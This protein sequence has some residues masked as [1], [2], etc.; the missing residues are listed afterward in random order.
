[1]KLKA[2]KCEFAKEEIKFLGFILSKEGIRPN[3]E[4]TRAIDQYPQPTNPTEANAECEATV[5][6]AAIPAGFI[7]IRR[8]LYTELSTYFRFKQDGTWTP[9]RRGGNQLGRMY[10]ASPRDTEKYAL[11]HLL[12][13]VRGATSF[14]QLRS[15]VDENGNAVVHPTFYA[16]ATAL[17]LFDDDE[18]HNATLREAALFATVLQMRSFVL[19]SHE[20]KDPMLLWNTFKRNFI[21]DYLHEGMSKEAIGSLLRP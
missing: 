17:G 13:C 9:R 2:S 16:A 18:S 19:C 5:N 12:L 21:D 3:P 7:D 10:T 11:R 20:V 4:K 6:S 1:M 15:V 14:E 8:Y